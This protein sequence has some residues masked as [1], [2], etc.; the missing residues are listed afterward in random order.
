MIT[1]ERIL[2][3]FLVPLVLLLG[4][5]LYPLLYAFS[6]HP[7]HV[8]LVFRYNLF[9]LCFS[10]AGAMIMAV[11][12]LFFTR[13]MFVEQK[14]VFFKFFLGTTIVFSA[15]FLFFTLQ[16]IPSLFKDTAEGYGR[17]FLA[18]TF[19]PVSALLSLIY[20]FLVYE[21]RKVFTSTGK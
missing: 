11:L 6:D 20:W 12:Y 17:L 21:R 13:K 8:N 7:E 3:Y 4:V 16:Y 18:T 1:L 5:L 15:F 9:V 10:I 2:T 14:E 19:P